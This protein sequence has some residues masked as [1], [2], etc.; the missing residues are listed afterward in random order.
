MRYRIKE[1]LYIFVFNLEFLFVGFVCFLVLVYFFW[2]CFYSRRFVIGGFS[3]LVS[4][5]YVFLGG[6]LSFFSNVLNICFGFLFYFIIRFCV[7]VMLFWKIKSK[8]ESFGGE[9]LWE[10]SLE[11]ETKLEN[12]IDFF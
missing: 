10:G 7:N 3:F 12:E 5:E 11:R 9:R 8:K 6:G 2:Y 1:V 4:I